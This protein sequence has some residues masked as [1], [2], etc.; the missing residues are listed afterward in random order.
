MVSYGA[1]STD[2]RTQSHWRARCSVY[3]EWAT[4]KNNIMDVTYRIA[5]THYV[6]YYR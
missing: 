2:Y 4:V 1:V 6:I 3:T 5:R